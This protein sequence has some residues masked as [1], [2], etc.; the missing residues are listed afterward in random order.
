[1]KEKIAD[2]KQKR[3]KLVDEARELIERAE[4]DNRAMTATEEERH[5]ALVGGKFNGKE[6][7]GETFELAKRISQLERMEAIEMSGGELSPEGRRSAP[8]PHQD[9][10]NVGRRH[11]YRMMRAIRSIASKGAEPFAGLEAEVSQ[12]I[13]R[14]SGKSP[15]GFML[16][17]STKGP[18]T[19]AERKAYE[20]GVEFRALDSAQG[21]G[22]VP[23]ILAAD[24]IELLR[25]RTVVIKAGARQIMDVQGKFAIPRQN[26]AGTAYWVAESGAPTGSN[27]TLDQVVFTP[28]TIGAFTDV[29]RRFFE[30]TMLDSGEEF[31]KDDLTAILARGTDLAALNGSGGAN[32][33]LGVM[34]N[35]G[36]A[37][38]ALGTNGLAPT[39]AGLVAL[40]TKLGK[41]NALDLGD[42]AYI[43]NADMNGT[44]A[45]T[46]KIGSTFPVF[47]LEN[48]QVNGRPIY[49]TQQVPA[50]LTKG[51]SGATL[52]A[53]LYG[54]WNQLVMAYWSGV[55][56]LVD[57]YTGSSSGTVR[58]VALQDMDIQL[59]H[60]EAFAMIV[61]AISNQ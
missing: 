15:Q 5:V 44:L 35:P 1:M 38:V 23:T 2:L 21:G 24:W 31:A 50:N 34:Q 25:N 26:A 6:H 45:T 4:K 33:P 48:G 43:S 19:D 51:S 12:E 27:Q 11:H 47:L 37:V 3:A 10:R 18:L 53:I 20:E 55:D 46:A 13:A 36:T 30:L 42:T 7:E 16:P 57:P 29:S 56:I 39:W 54:V 28:K 41:G 49:F 22:S 59:R 40:N 17:Y 8:L 52:S 60:N 32:Q 14:R 9:P 58:V 61:D